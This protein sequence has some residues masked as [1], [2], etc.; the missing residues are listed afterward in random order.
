MFI[1]D[2][3]I[4]QSSDLER[5]FNCLCARMNDE[6][7]TDLFRSRTLDNRSPLVFA[8]GHYYCP[9]SIIQQ[10]TEYNDDNNQLVLAFDNVAKYRTKNFDVLKPLL[11]R[12]ESEINYQNEL[13]QVVCRH[14]YT[15]ILEWLLSNKY[16]TRK[17]RTKWKQ[18]NF[19]III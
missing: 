15:Q 19:Y 3:P 14:D 6:K 7:K 2:D 12:F 13:V 4:Q 11:K 10:L 16:I 1:R 18:L 9:E 8:V 5:M 17:F